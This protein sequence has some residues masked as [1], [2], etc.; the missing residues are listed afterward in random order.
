MGLKRPPAGLP[1][2]LAD[3]GPSPRVDVVH[4]S[5]SPRGTYRVTFR[6]GPRSM[7]T[8]AWFRGTEYVEHT[9]DDQFPGPHPDDPTLGGMPPL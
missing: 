5:T 1:V 4:Y 9:S 3:N 8:K 7:G 2:H 6:V